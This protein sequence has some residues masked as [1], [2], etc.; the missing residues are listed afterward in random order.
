MLT[1]GGRVTCFSHRYHNTG[2]D[3]Y[4]ADINDYWNRYAAE[5]GI[6]RIVGHGRFV[7][8]DTVQVNGE[9]YRA[10]HIVI[11]TGSQAL[12]PP[13][14][15]AEQG[16]TWDGFFQLRQQP[17]RV[18]INGG[19]Y[20]GVELAGMLSALGSEVTIVALE[21]RL[22]ELFDP[23]IC[24][25][26]MAEMP[27]Q[28]IE[29]RMGFRVTGLTRTAAGIAVQSADGAGLDGYDGVLWA[30]GRAPNTGNLNLAAAGVAV[31]SNGIVPV[32][33]YRNTNVTGIFAIGDVTGKAP[34]TP[35]AIAAGRR[36]AERL[37]DGQPE[38]RLDYANVPSVVF[39][40]PP[41]GTVGLTETQARE[42]YDRAVTVYKTQF[43]PMR[44]VLAEHSASI[45]M[46]LVCAGD[47]QKVV[48]VH[49]VGENADE[50]LQ[51]SAVP[52]KMGATKADLDDTVA[53]HPTSVE[54]LVT[55]KVPESPPVADERTDDGVLWREAS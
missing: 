3:R 42:R 47:E 32:D 17:R 44:Y 4:I 13:L 16:I 14:P 36:L 46:K 31:L 8:A 20:V 38:R 11:A 25:V 39:S 45:A 5:Q 23:M 48:G 49:I 26:P 7:D 1:R 19:G 28:G 18:A 55:M 21:E 40:H 12:V 30:V 52:V 33:D 6:D 2:R 29:L 10:G 37:F 24:E 22:L 9:R 34:L 41:I 27:K 53:I 15:G 43:T 51:G 35:V 54:E 50:M